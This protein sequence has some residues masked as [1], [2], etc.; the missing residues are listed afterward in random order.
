[1]IDLFRPRKASILIENVFNKKV[2]LAQYRLQGI[3]TVQIGPFRLHRSAAARRRSRGPPAPYVAGAHL[4]GAA[5]WDCCLPD[6]PRRENRTDQGRAHI[7]L[8]PPSEALL[9]A[10]LPLLICFSFSSPFSN[11]LPSKTLSKNLYY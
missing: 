9:I 4:A 7:Q 2:L 6:L 1:M 5:A 10:L 3:W 11:G 8:L